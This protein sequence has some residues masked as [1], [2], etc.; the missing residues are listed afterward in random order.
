M[1]VPE[2]RWPTMP[3]TLASTSFCATVLPTFGSAWSS[4]AMISNLTFLPPMVTPAALASSMA[5]RTP[6]SLSLPRCAMPPVSGATLPI[7]ITIGGGGAW[8]GG[9]GGGSS[10]P[11]PIRATR[12]SRQAKWFHGHIHG[13]AP[14]RSGESGI[15]R[16]NGKSRHG[17]LPSCTG[18]SMSFLLS[19]RHIPAGDAIHCFGTD[20]PRKG[21]PSPLPARTK[22]GRCRKSRDRPWLRQ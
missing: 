18:L 13:E 8:T 7:L 4:S 1:V 10:L 16:R 6:F 12:Q 2:L 21:V 14:F 3:A 9:G 15:I 11:Q 17:F 22:K 19:A 5:R 20:I